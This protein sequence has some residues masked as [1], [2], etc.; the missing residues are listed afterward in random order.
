MINLF[1]Y[2]DRPSSIHRLTGASKL[3]C[4]IAWSLAAMTSFYTPLLLVL[5]AASFLLFRYAKLKVKDI[6][7][8]LSLMLVYVCYTGNIILRA[9]CDVSKLE[10]SNYFFAR[11]DFKTICVYGKNDLIYV[12]VSSNHSAHI[13]TVGICCPSITA[14]CEPILERDV[15]SACVIYNV[16]DL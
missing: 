13:Y 10:R 5:T 9:V 3:V 7:F 14:I 16:N 4:L 15:F 8:V 12:T 2:I 6:S 11:Q 1:N